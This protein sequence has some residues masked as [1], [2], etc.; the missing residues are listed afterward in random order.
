MYCSTGSDSLTLALILACI[1]YLALLY[2]LSTD[3]YCSL[4]SNPNYKVYPL[5]SYPL[6]HLATRAMGGYSAEA[7]SDY[8]LV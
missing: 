2:M 7:I 1:C 8:T 6:A 5:R 4:H 3:S